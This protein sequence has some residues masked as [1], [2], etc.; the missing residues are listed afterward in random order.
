LT[1]PFSPNRQDD[2][3]P[4]PID[5]VLPRLRT[6]LA[7][8]HAV[9]SA[10]PGSGKTTHVPLALLDE[11]WLAGLRLL[12]LEPRRPAARMAAARMAHLRAE[13][14]GDTVG[15]Q[16][17]FERR[18]GRRTR[19]EVLTEGILTRRLQQDPGLEGVGLLIFDELHERSLQGDLGLAL[20][21]DVASQLRGDLRILVMSATLDTPAVA[22][23]LD[24]APVILGE[25]RS[26][27]VGLVYSEL[28]ATKDREGAVV[29]SVRRAL[30]ESQGDVLAFLPGAA[31]IRRVQDRLSPII[32]AEVEILPLHGGLSAAEQDCALRPNTGHGRRVVLA[33]DIAET[34][35]TIEGVTAV[36]DSGLARKPRFDPASGLTRLVTEPISRASADQRSGRAGRLG[37]GI[38]YRLWTRAQEAGR[39]E[40]RT[41]EILQADLAP[42]VLELAVWGIRDP[43]R[44][45]WLDPPPAGAWSHGVRLLQL[46]G[47]LDQVGAITGTGR[48]MA[49]LPVHPRLARMLIGGHGKDASRPAADLA[50]LLS[51]R[52][53]WLSRPGLPRPADIRLRLQALEQLRASGEAAGAER[54][55][56][57]AADRLSRQLL[58]IMGTDKDG[59]NPESG[60][61]LALAYPDRVAKRRPG[62]DGRY[63]L[64]AG[65]GAVLPPDDPLAVHELLVVAEVDALQREGRIRLALPIS[66]AALRDALADHIET[67]DRVRWDTSADGVT[68]RREERLGALR[69]SARPQPLAD[70]EAAARLL[71]EQITQR[72]DQVLPWSNEVRQLQARVALLRRIEPEDGWPDL[73]DDWLRRNLAE[74]LTA[75]LQG[76]RRIA[77]VRQLNLKAVLLARLDWKHQERLKAQAPELLRTPA[78]TRR[79]LDYSAGTEPVLA[80]R[81]QEMFGATETPTVCDGRIPVTLHLLSPAQRPVQVTRD[82]AGFWE[83]G[84]AEVRKELRGRYA[85][86]QWPEDPAKAQPV[87]GGTK[88][89]R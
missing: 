83:R 6:A 37:P 87:A 50:A 41:A 73:S 44:L 29:A 52:D 35:L 26:Y 33:T 85:K 18:I 10:P 27:P 66:E 48:R 82:L 46:L 23:L 77:E 49:Q 53:P 3:A 1:P 55:G 5:D 60:A 67:A 42:L 4:L 74:W 84:Y 61:L 89:R 36:V 39:P 57:V 59:A 28:N 31:E 15:Y 45:A 47:A 63:L 72:F 32:G 24:E 88:R 30:S 64:A 80:V 21:L 40:H 43:S 65:P 17:R 81:L 70:P 7:R 69:I 16:V 13:A 20:A 75:W 76:M 58:R 25:G 71:T 14:T 51:D 34:S 86:H 62:A 9:L 8:G 79:R 12:M 19:I 68:A 2:S 11:P 54:R 56:L 22:R 38:C 78:G